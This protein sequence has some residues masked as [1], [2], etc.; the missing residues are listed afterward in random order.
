MINVLL[1]GCVC[2]CGGFLFVFVVFFLISWKFILIWGQI[3]YF[4]FF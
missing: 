1:E 3:Y 2:V 4:P